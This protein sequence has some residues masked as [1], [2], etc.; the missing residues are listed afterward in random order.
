MEACPICGG[1]MKA[2]NLE[3]TSQVECE[4]CGRYKVTSSVIPLL[5]D[6]EHLTPRQKANISGWLYEN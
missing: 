4:R 5:R 3:D 6:S 1:S 2:V